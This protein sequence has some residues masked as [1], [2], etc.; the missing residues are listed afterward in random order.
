MVKIRLKWAAMLLVA[1]AAAGLLTGCSGSSFFYRSV[2]KAQEALDNA[3][4]DNS[5]A[6]EEGTTSIDSN[7]TSEEKAEENSDR[8]ENISAKCTFAY[9]QMTDSRKETYRK[10]YDAISSEKQ[11]F[12]IYVEKTD[13]IEPALQGLLM[14]HP[15]LFWL[16]GDAKID[17][18]AGGGMER[19][20][21]TFNIDPSEISSVRDRIEACVSE[22]LNAL[23]ENATDYTKAR[24]AY[25]Y[26]IRNTDYG[27]GSSQNQNIQSV[28]LYHKSVC[29]GYAKAFQYL[30]HRADVPC[31]YITGTIAGE[32]EAHAWNMASL[33][34]VN[35]LIDPTWGD[36]TYDAS[37][38]DSR[39]LDIIY[40]YLCVTSEEMVR[41]H[42]VP[43]AEYSVPD[44]TSTDYDFYR[45]LGDYMT[46]YDA[47]TIQNHLYATV[48]G[49]ESVTYLKFENETDYQAALSGIFSEGGL[50]EEPLQEKMR[51]DGTDSI[52]YFYSKSDEMR[53]IKIFW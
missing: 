9:D 5:P 46:S 22:Y 4:S 50:I 39:R 47:D 7:H 24:A 31:A 45:L 36:P 21:L 28:F 49:G 29:A 8:D 40:D 23:P 43:S 35:T 20:S 19:I 34:G 13:D 26:V 1:L 16:D 12:S 48:R 25:Q 51:I 27:A 17:G 37:N 11:S 44:C 18:T 2:Q 32:G 52:Q 15:E 33:N 53:T 38:E 42:H 6:V 3:L 30:L 10:L 14:D 41:S